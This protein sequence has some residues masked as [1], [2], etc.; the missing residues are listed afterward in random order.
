MDWIL[1]Y[2][3]LQ[4]KK[5]NKYFRKGF[6]KH[7]WILMRIQ[8]VWTLWDLPWTPWDLLWISWDHPPL[9]AEFF[10]RMKNGARSKSSLKMTELQACHSKKINGV[11]GRT[12]LRNPAVS[13]RGIP[14]IRLGLPSGWF[15]LHASQQFYF[16]INFM[17]PGDFLKWT[18]IFLYD[19]SGFEWN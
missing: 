19:Q 16:H 4:L 5:H 7:N 18:K 10:F 9:P 2:W 15:Y 14:P 12:G 1:H 3:L 17:K 8:K 6:P 13:Y 11:Y